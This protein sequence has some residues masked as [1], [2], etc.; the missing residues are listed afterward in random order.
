MKYQGLI[1][2]F[3]LSTFFRQWMSQR[4]ELFEKLFR[5]ISLLMTAAILQLYFAI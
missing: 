3:H 2:M 4:E 5:S 1:Q